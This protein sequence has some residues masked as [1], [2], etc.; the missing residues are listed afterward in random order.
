[1][2]GGLARPVWPMTGGLAWR[3]RY[4]RPIDRRVGAAGV[5]GR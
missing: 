1:M 5:P 2:T 4:G 3:D